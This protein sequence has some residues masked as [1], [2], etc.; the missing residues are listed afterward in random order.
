MKVKDV[1][2]F[3]LN[4]LVL[5]MVMMTP[6][7]AHGLEVRLSGSEFERRRLPAQMETALYRI[8]QEALTNVVRHARAS[9]V[10]IIL[11]PREDDILLVVEDDGVGF[12]PSTPL[13]PGHLGLIGI[14]ERAEAFGGQ[15]VIDSSPNHG[16]TLV[17]RIRDADTSAD[18]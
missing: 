2:Y 5:M 16:T 7:L 17:V 9:R 15:L 14:R 1:G 3:P 6:S 13:S 10:D 8:V 12:E 4:V 11:Q 18:R